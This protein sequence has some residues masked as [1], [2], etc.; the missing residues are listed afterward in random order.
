MIGRT[1]R[2]LHSRLGLAIYLAGTALVFSFICFEVLDLDGSDFPAKPSA[3]ATPANLAEASHDLRRAF[4]KAMA[5]SWRDVPLLPSDWSGETARL[6]RSG[7][8]E[9]SLVVF[10]RAH[11]TR[12][13]LPRASLADSPPSA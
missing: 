10:P 3:A 1:R 5:P 2:L 8:L 4:L 9:L 11:G 13:T 12:M 7:P 6:Q